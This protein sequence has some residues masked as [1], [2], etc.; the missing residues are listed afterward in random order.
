MNYTVPTYWRSRII[1]MLQCEGQEGLKT[2][3]IRDEVSLALM[4][5]MKKSYATPLDGISDDDIF[6]YLEAL[7]NI[8][9]P[10]PPV[11]DFKDFVKTSSYRAL[12]DHGH[13]L[14]QKEVL[15]SLTVCEAGELSINFK[16][17]DDETR[18]RYEKEILD[19][20]RNPATVYDASIIYEEL[21]NRSRPVPSYGVPAFFGLVKT[22]TSGYTNDS[23][24]FVICHALDTVRHSV[25]EEL[26]KLQATLLPQTVGHQAPTP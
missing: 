12:C 13:A 16:H 7:G 26:T 25:L 24:D 11:D 18:S 5:N 4:E 9:L 23:I 19:I 21:E 15:A 20:S 14:I 10:L 8:S 3:G 2:L 17:L 6:Q 22:E 1:Y